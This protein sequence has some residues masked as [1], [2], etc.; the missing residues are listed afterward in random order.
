MLAPDG[1]WVTE[2]PVATRSLWHIEMTNNLLTA[3]LTASICRACS[4]CLGQIC[5]STRTQMSRESKC[6][7]VVK[8]IVEMYHAR[9]INQDR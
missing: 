7:I 1:L 6:I 8:E 3:S 4:Q 5:A 2:F 9:S